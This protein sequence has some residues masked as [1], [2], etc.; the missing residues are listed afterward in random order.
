MKLSATVLRALNCFF[1]VYAATEIKWIIMNVNMLSSQH[2]MI[3]K[4]IVKE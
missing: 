1:K 2:G 4:A 3:K